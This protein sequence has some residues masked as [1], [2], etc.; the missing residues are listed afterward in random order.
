MIDLSKSHDFFQPEKVPQRIHI[1]GC[2]AVGATIAENLVRFGLTNLTLW[3]FDNVEGKNVHNQIYRYADVGRPKVEALYNLLV[4]I[5]PDCAETI[6]LEPEGWDGETLSGYVFLAVDKIAIRRAIAESNKLNMNI[7]A[8]FDVRN[9]LTSTQL[10]FADWANAKQKEN[11]I[12]TMNFSDDEVGENERVSACGE[13][14]GVAV[15]SR[16]AAAFT[17]ANF[18]NFTKGEPTKFM[19]SIDIFK[20]EIAAF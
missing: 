2:G 7:K 11:F 5:N 6:E 1:V 13:T 19:Q 14:L 16:V 17:A 18:I 10:Y 15:T 4:E 20:S 9:A 3:D 12:A 8:M